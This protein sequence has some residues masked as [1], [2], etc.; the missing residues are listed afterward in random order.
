[1]VLR[2]SPATAAARPR[3]DWQ[4]EAVGFEQL[5]MAYLQRPAR[6]ANSSNLAQDAQPPG[7]TTKVMSR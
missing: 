1:V 3:P 7:P 2:T 4:S 6:A 5:V